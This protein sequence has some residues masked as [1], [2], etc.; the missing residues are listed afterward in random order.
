MNGKLP[1]LAS[2]VG[3]ERR[4]AACGQSRTS[5]LR[6]SHLVRPPRQVDVLILSLLSAS[7]GFRIALHYHP[8]GSVTDILALDLGDWLNQAYGGDGGQL[9]PGAWAANQYD[10]LVTVAGLEPVRKASKSQ[11]SKPAFRKAFRALEHSEGQ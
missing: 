2:R 8:D 3:G 9:R 7:A 11:P 1:C 6:L 5:G 4:P 10:G